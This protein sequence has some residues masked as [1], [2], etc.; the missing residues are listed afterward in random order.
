MARVEEVLC[1]VGNEIY[2]FDVENVKG[3]E[4]YVNIVPV[5]NAPSYIEGIIN[6]R[7][8][9][10]PIY[11]LRHKFNLPGTA[12]TEETKLIISKSKEMLIGFKVDKVHGIVGIEEEE[13][14]EVPTIVKIEETA[15]IKTIA[16][17]EERLVI[18]LDLEVML[19]GKESKEIRDIIEE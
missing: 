19:T 13:F 2:G 11:N 1:S 16:K 5:P 18:I 15:Y 7:E 14:L 12:P 8:D 6:L 17:V 9:V 4:K 3:I 10:I